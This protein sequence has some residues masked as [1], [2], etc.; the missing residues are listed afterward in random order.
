VPTIDFIER[1]I[2]RVDGFDVRFR[3]RDGKDVRG[4]LELARGYGFQNSGPH[5]MTVQDW[6]RNRFEPNYPG[7]TCEVLD[8]RGRA[9]SGN[10]LLSTVRASYA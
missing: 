4:D 5:T 10:T 9:V 2:R 1:Q 3:H 7:F 6:K 8:G